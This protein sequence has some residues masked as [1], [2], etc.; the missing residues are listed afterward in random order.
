MAKSKRKKK[1]NIL[2]ILSD[3]QRWDSIG[4]SNVFKGVK[5]PN[6]DKI[7]SKGIFFSHCFTP[8][9]ILLFS[10]SIQMHPQ[11]SV[12]GGQPVRSAAGAPALVNVAH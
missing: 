9:E 11:T 6:I 5:T 1:K 7:A 12:D 2:F 4:V 3:E 8:K 10:S